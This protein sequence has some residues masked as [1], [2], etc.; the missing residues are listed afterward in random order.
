MTKEQTER[1]EEIQKNDTEPHAL[2][3]V[4]DLVFDRTFLLSLISELQAENVWHDVEKEQPA[5]GE[6][7]FAQLNGAYDCAYFGGENK[8][9]RYIGKFFTY[10]EKTDEEYEGYSSI[11][12]WM[13]IP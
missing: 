10:E 4:R 3:N 7:I 9:K 5:I 12:F 1:L 6:L 8:D 11:Q 13:K 2:R